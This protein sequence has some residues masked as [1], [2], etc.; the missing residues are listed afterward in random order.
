M[1][2]INL[3]IL[4]LLMAMSLSAQQ[5]KRP[6]TFDDIL[7][8]NRITETIISNDGNY[9]VYKTEPVEEAIQILELSAETG[10][11]LN[12][13]ILLLNQKSQIIR[14]YLIYTNCYSAEELRPLKLKK[15]KKDEMPLNKLG[16]VSL[17]SMKIDTIN[18]LKS[19]KVPQESGT[20][21][22]PIRQKQKLRKIQQ[23]KRIKRKQKK[24]PMM[25]DLN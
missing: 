5:N 4:V 11:K 18:E 8:W 19:Y 10:K 14:T 6:L 15:T 20:D 7:K 24:N 9:V 16:L 25:M 3:L 22:L 2:K 21:G 13:W 17:S 23:N 1:K 12:D